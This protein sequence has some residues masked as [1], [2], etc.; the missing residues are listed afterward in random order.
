M[1]LDSF[2]KLLVDELEI[3]PVKFPHSSGYCASCKKAKHSQLEAAGSG[4][5]SCLFYSLNTEG[6]V[7]KDSFGAT[8]LH[9][10][11]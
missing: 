5:E 2:D 11:N 9:I 8:A 7:A 1:D 6:L 10:G 3:K 4:H